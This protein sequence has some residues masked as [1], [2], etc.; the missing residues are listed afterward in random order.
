MTNPRPLFI[1][2]LV[3]TLIVTVLTVG[4]NHFFPY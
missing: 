3:L 4:L 1:V 2:A